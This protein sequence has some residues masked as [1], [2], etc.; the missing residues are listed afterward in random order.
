MYDEHSVG[1]EVSLKINRL[2]ARHKLECTFVLFGCQSGETH[3][4]EREYR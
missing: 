2:I 3:S 4:K 1:D